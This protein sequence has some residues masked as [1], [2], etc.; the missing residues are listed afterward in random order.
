M[1]L[2]DAFATKQSGR[3]KA[4]PLLGPLLEEPIEG[5]DQGCAATANPASLNRGASARAHA[6]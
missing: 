1:A 2:S 3:A 6:S 5:F 4:W